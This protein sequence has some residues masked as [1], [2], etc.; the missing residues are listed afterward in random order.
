MSFRR[1]ETVL[2]SNFSQLP[3]N[4]QTLIHARLLH[5]SSPRYRTPFSFPTHPNPTPHEIFH[6]PR[7][8]S[9]ADIK[10]RYIALV[11]QHHPDSPACRALPSD[12]RHR[13]FQLV[14][15]AYDTLRGKT[16]SMSGGPRRQPQ[17]QDTWDEIDRRK[18]AYARYQAGYARARRA[19]FSSGYSPGY[20]DPFSWKRHRPVQDDGWVDRLIL[21]FGFTAL[22]V[23]ILPMYLYPRP[24]YPRLPDSA[25]HL[26]QARR[27]AMLTR[28]D[29]MRVQEH[30]EP[31]S[32]YEND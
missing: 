27:E 26:A 18:N 7:G 15:A 4:L 23:G 11:K 25:F 22:I 1:L 12:E 9:D 19:E 14:S 17:D 10:R 8:A 32:D 31:D 3:H 20:E 6:L 30:Q 28:D 13:R 24:V 29:R 5:Q 2:S 21:A 16:V